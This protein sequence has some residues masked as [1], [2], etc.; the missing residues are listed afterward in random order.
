MHIFKVLKKLNNIFSNRQRLQ[1]F[2][3][4]IMMVIGGILE[5]FSVSL[6]LP[7]VN[8]FMEPEKTMDT[9]YARFICDT[10]GIE[11]SRGFLVL[12]AIV[13]AMI[14]LLKNIFFVVEYNSQYRFVYD[15]MLIMQERILSNLIHRPY[16]FFLR[17][18]S[19]EIV[20]II[21]TDAP[22][23]FVLIISML[24]LFTEF[25]VSGMI[26]LTVLIIAPVITLIMACVLLVIVLIINY[27]IKPILRKAGEDVQ[28]SSAGMNK[29]LLQS[30]MGIKELKVASKENYFSRKF[31][32]HGDKYVEALRK[33]NVF[34]IVPRFVIEA[35]SMCT[36]FGIVAV[37]IWNGTDLELIVPMLTAIAM[38][39]MRL[40]PAMSRISQ[41][42]GHISYNEPMLDK[43][44]ENLKMISDSEKVSFDMELG[45]DK[46]A[47]AGSITSFDREI[48]MSGV[49]F[50]Y[51]GTD[52]D[53]L[54][55]A[56]FS[57]KKGQSVGI[58][59][60]SG[61]GKTTAVDILL[62]L[63]EPK[64][65]GVFI[66]GKNIQEDMPGFLSLVGYIP[67]SI[68]MMDDTI[69]ANVAFGDEEATDDDVWRALKDASLYDFVKGLPE[70]LDTEIGE[71]GIR[72]SGGQKQR[73]GIAR[74]LFRNPEILFFDEATSS[75]DNDT[76]KS[77]MESIEHL[78]GQKTLVIIAHRLTTI[79]NCDVVY[80]VENGAVSKER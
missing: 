65:G 42:L 4:V 35:V 71:R 22:Q 14:F 59:G 52:S 27:L 29:W 78:K 39:A 10:F 76:E 50:G 38:A 16:E 66:D 20:R 1:I 72:L 55:A 12:I 33:S 9:W 47:S 15:N 41:L 37:L 31:N 67:Q 61:A 26:I 6:V 73:V 28:E 79:E 69:R 23:A 80:R 18:S 48:S 68:F 45:V 21:N 13:L 75:L 62:G 3:L 51:P 34:V 8:A 58:V 56:D 36:I 24:Q 2:K 53:V 5:I 19:G 63:L 70:G 17:V 57:I 7:F 54:S 40:I 32:V 44:I 43:L 11:S 64:G 60:A 46:K 74:A 30:V 49:T 77:I 25:F